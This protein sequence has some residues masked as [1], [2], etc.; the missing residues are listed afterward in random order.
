MAGTPSTVRVSRLGTAPQ[1]SA[2]VRIPGRAYEVRRSSGSYPVTAVP[3]PGSPVM[4]LAS[5][6]A[7]FVV[8]SPPELAERVAEVGERF[9]RTGAA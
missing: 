3:L 8:E 4:V 6:G 5:C 1:V 2:I 7:D 9:A